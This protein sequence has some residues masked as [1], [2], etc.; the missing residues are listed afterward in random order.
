MLGDLGTVLPYVPKA[1]GK[2]PATGWYLELTPQTIDTASCVLWLTT[3]G[4][5]YAGIDVVRAAA[6]IERLYASI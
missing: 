4:A 2:L 3:G 5:V 1:N 6:T